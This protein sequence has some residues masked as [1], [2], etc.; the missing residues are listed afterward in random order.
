VY[1]RQENKER[2]SFA[3]LGNQYATSSP[4][5]L[6]NMEKQKEINWQM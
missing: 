5:K 2:E 3:K 6:K 4:F 1:L